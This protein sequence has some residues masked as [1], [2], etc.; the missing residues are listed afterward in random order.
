VSQGAQNG[1]A[2]RAVRRYS[3]YSDLRLT[4]EGFSTE[5][6][7][8]VPDISAQGMFINTVRQFPEGAILKVSFHL[9]KSGV[10]IQTR[11]EVRYCLKDVGV[12]LEFIGLDEPSKEAIEREMLARAHDVDTAFRHLSSRRQEQT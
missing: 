8:R 12:G 11:A 9:P 1:T 7:I 10:N 5:V 3:A 6:S 4:Y 2:K